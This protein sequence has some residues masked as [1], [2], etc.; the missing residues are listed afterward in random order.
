MWAGGRFVFH[1]PLRVDEAITRVSTVQDVTVK[2]SRNG[3]LCFVL[4]RH[5]VAGQ[6][7]LALAEEHDIVY[8][9]LPHPGEAPATPRPVRTDDVWV[10]DI[11]PGEAQLF[12]Y[13]ALT[14]NSHRIHY[15]RRV[16]LC[17]DAAHIWVPNAGY[18]MNAGIA[19]AMNLSWMLAGV[20]KGWAS[21]AILDCYETERMP[22]TAQVSHYA[23]DTSAALAR[24]RGVI[25]ENIEQPG[26]DGDAA[27]ARLG[28]D[29]YDINVGQF[30]CGGLNFGS[31]IE[32]SPI[33]EHDGAAPGYTIYDFAPSTV[34]GCR[35]P[36][37]R[38]EEGV[39]L[40]DAMGP[41]FTL[42]RFDPRLDV[43]NLLAAAE[44]RGMPLTLLDVS[45]TEPVYAEKLILSRPDQH[46][47]WR[48]NTVPV[49]PL[50]L[51]DR[52]R[53]AGGFVVCHDAFVLLT[54][55][56][57]AGCGNFPARSR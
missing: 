39:S 8:R 10:R 49:D 17:G 14:F 42:L 20:L 35:T 1:Q 40:Y 52:V 21:P 37:F 7:G 34:P 18:G 2:H 44:S 36:H 11:H 26:P 45:T 32:N 41:D 15:D 12:R 28:R 51:I 3:A 16:F 50:P 48:G 13:S 24:Q 54:A 38:L 55:Q 43:A 25:P 31:F 30:C 9:D 33:I 27:R 19:D 29:A 6:D 53:G 4:V 57:L 47:A 23:M 56:V 22:I 46:I 5:E